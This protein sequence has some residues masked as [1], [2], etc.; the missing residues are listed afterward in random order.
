MLSAKEISQLVIDAYSHLYFISYNEKDI[1]FNNYKLGGISGEIEAIKALKNNDLPKM[2]RMLS[3]L[4]ERIKEYDRETPIF[5]KQMENYNKIYNNPDLC[6][7]LGTLKN[8]KDAIDS[9]TQNLNRLKEIYR[10]FIYHLY[11]LEK[12]NF[13]NLIYKTDSTEDEIVG[14]ATTLLD[15]M[16][17]IKNFREKEIITEH[18]ESISEMETE[19]F[20]IGYALVGKGLVDLAVECWLKIPENSVHYKKAHF[21]AFECVYYAKLDIKKTAFR[22]FMK[23][24]PACYSEREQLITFSENE[25]RVFNSCLLSA[26]GIEAKIQII[27]SFDKKTIN[28]LLKYVFLKAVLDDLKTHPEIKF[29]QTNTF[30]AEERVQ[31][32]LSKLDKLLPP[33]PLSMQNL[34]NLDEIINGEGGKEGLWEKSKPAISS[35]SFFNESLKP[36]IKGFYK[37][38][39]QQQELDEPKHK[40]LSGQG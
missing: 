10:L 23:A 24:L 14:C 33:L 35:A 28:L 31:G 25:R 3:R 26:L 8:P 11:T 12:Q 18:V 30:F 6:K 22:A 21:E 36:M 37:H 16:E 4:E 5:T 29:K 19:W 7:H 13:N 27:D 38:E 9:R 2:S 20:K 32:L 39:A 34:Q 15:H 40:G 17:K 1:N